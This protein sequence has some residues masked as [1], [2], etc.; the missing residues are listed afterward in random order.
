[1]LPRASA[2]N[3]TRWPS[4]AQEELPWHGEERIQEGLANAVT[5]VGLR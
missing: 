3:G 4:K 5:T 2:K 1:M